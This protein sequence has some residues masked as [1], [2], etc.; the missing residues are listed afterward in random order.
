M[1]TAP[2]PQGRPSSEGVEKV[3]RKF[4][5]WEQEEQELEKMLEAQQ[6]KAKKM[7]RT[8]VSH[9]LLYTHS[10]SPVEADLLL[11]FRLKAPG[12]KCFGE[13]VLVAL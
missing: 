8:I 6:K 9:D 1:E 3:Q 4:K 7:D 12:G 2:R 10:S 5:G 11:T 13:A